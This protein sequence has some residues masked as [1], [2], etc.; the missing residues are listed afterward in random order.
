MTTLEVR[1]VDT[2]KLVGHIRQTG[3]HAITSDPPHLIVLTRQ[4]LELGQSA[5]Q[6]MTSLDGWSNGYITVRS[7]G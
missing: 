1:E 7:A 5:D 6:V 2:D 4:F 3:T